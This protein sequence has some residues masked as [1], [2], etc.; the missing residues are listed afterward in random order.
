MEHPSIKEI[1][2]VLKRLIL[3]CPTFVLL[4]I[5]L[6]IKSFVITGSSA[7]GAKIA[8]FQFQLTASEVSTYL[9]LSAGTGAILGNLSGKYIAAYNLSFLLKG[10]CCKIRKLVKSTSNKHLYKIDCYKQFESNDLL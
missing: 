10:I 1:P 3:K 2:S 5:A 9:A 6:S 7:F 8:L 4:S